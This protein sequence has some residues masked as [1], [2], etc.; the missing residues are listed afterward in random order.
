[1][2]TFIRITL[3]IIRCACLLTATL[4]IGPLAHAT[5]PEQ[6]LWIVDKENNG[7]P[8]R[9]FFIDIQG[10]I[11]VMS[12]YTYN[13]TQTNQWY[14]SSGPMNGNSFNG[15]LEKYEGGTYFGGAYRPA[16]YLGIEGRV[17]VNFSSAT[18]GTI[19]FPLE[20]P[21]PISRFIFGRPIGTNELN[22]TYNLERAT[23]TYHAT[24]STLDTLKNI[25]A[26]G[27]MAI[28]GASMTQ[29]I[30]V[31]TNNRTTPVAA[32][33]KILSRDAA[34]LTILN[35]QVAGISNIT[36]IKSG[37]EFITMM[38]TTEY[39]EINYWRRTSAFPTAL[40][41][42]SAPAPDTAGITPTVIGAS[43]GELNLLEKE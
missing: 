6:G 43:L 34:G 32:G 2:T 13:S 36:L 40:N 7:Q 26:T 9:G 31:T 28:D 35:N 23:V 30:T 11:L 38:V 20:E 5:T 12:V 17:Q 3:Q 1:M 37:D 42:R 33:G 39:S 10:Q 4:I 21:K 29:N 41:L 14:L 24:M 19:Q 8:G 25:A 16:R 27:K 18:S 22:G 15:G